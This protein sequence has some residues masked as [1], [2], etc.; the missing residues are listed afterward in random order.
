MEKNIGRYLPAH[1]HAGKLVESLTLPLV[2]AVGATLKFYDN[3]SRYAKL[4]GQEMRDRLSRGE[5][6]YLLG[7]C[8][9]GHNST[10]ALVEV[11]AKN[12]ILPIRNNEEERFTG[13]R[14]EDR[15][16]ENSLKEIFELLEK[17]DVNPADILTVVGS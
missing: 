9:S 1:P 14:H 13:I 2:R 17:R 5:S 6:V 12:G 11:S 10:A 7:V 8:P 16:P 4:K 15:F 3:R